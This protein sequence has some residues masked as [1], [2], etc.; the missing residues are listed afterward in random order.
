MA[1]GALWIFLSQSLTCFL[2]ESLVCLV[3][4]FDYHV[5]LPKPAASERATILEQAVAARGFVCRS[6]VASEVAMSFDGADGSDLVS[7]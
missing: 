3:G 1:L 4:R 6:S 7:S 2:N 5:E